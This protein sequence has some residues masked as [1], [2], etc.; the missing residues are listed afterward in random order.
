LTAWGCAPVRVE[1]T[2]H[3][4]ARQ[5]QIADSVQESATNGR[6]ARRAYALRL[7]TFERPL[8]TEFTRRGPEYGIP[9]DYTR[10]AREEVRAKWNSVAIKSYE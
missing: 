9:I 1:E 3:K 4:A 5:L 10:H 2:L 6:Y 8:S 7:S